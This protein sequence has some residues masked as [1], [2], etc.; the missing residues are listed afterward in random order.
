MVAIPAAVHPG[1]CRPP[2]SGLCRGGPV[3]LRL[4]WSAVAAGAHPS[5]AGTDTI[6]GPGHSIPP[7]GQAR[8]YTTTVNPS[9]AISKPDSSTSSVSGDAGSHRGL[10]WL[11]WVRTILVPMS[12]KRSMVSVTSG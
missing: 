7:S 6:Q 1:G 11:R 8:P 2:V 9:W 12:E 10:V 4:V 5:R 3:R